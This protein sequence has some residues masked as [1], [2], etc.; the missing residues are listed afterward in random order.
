MEQSP[1]SNAATSGGPPRWRP[2]DRVERRVLGVLIEKAKT[3]PDSYPLS[4]NALKNGCNQKSNRFPSMQLE[5]DEIEEVMERLR[6]AGAAVVIQGGARVDK[7]RHLAYEWLGVNKVELAVMGELLLRGAQTVGELRGRAARMEPIKD[8]GELRP[9]LESLLAKRLLIYLTPE[10]RG[11][12]VS[13]NLYQPQELERVRREHGE[14]HFDA[15][16]PSEPLPRDDSP[17]AFVPDK[18]APAEPAGMRQPGLPPAARDVQHGIGDVA[19]KL[20]SVQQA[21]AATQADLAAL[22]DETAAAI[23]ELRREIEDFRRRVGDL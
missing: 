6:E 10:G 23:D 20:E 21:L 17:P 5:D 14:A 2:L 18:D 8:L 22:R 12:V 7:Y 11:A 15:R 4:L 16:S 19:E 1:N 9:V 3:T 13:H